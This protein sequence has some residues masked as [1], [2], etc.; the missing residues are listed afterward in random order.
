MVKSTYFKVGHLT[1]G[2]GFSFRFC[3]GIGFE[4]FGF[5]L[6]AGPFWLFVEW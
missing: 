5:N 3:I 4:K 6:D 1:I 2:V